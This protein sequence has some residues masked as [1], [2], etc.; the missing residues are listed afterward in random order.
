M[1]IILRIWVRPFLLPTVANQ[2][3]QFLHGD[4]VLYNLMGLVI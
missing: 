3:Q 2:Q 4:P 1:F